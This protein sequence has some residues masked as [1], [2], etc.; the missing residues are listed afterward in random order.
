VYFSNEE[1]I[2]LD[3]AENDDDNALYL[4]K[5]GEIE[6]FVNNGKNSA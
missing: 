1:L 5:E 3:K 2:F 4:I 6:L